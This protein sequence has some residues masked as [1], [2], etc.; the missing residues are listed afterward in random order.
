MGHGTFL[1]HEAAVNEVRDTRAREKQRGPSRTI[2]WNAAGVYPHP[3]L[4]KRAFAS[5]SPAS[6]C[7]LAGWALGAIVGVEADVFLG[8]IGG[9]KS[10]GG[11]AFAEG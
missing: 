3:A 10:D 5:D 11:R 1:C 7:L 8:Q 9:P 4:G 2:Y 6:K